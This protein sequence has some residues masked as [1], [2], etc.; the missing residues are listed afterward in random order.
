MRWQ[1]RARND[2]GESLRLPIKKVL[3]MHVESPPWTVVA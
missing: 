3:S 1:R 2:N